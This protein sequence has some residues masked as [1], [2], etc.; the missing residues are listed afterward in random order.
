MKS[1]AYCLP[2][3]P[4]C[5]NHPATHQPHSQNRWMNCCSVAQRSLD[6]PPADWGS[7]S[8]HPQWM[9]A[10]PTPL[11]YTC[12]PPVPQHLLKLPAEHLNC[13]LNCWN[14]LLNTWI[15][16]STVEITRWPPELP[17]QLLKSPADHLNCPLN[18][19]NHPLT[20]W[21]ALSTVEITCWTPESP[22]D[23]GTPTLSTCYTATVE[24]TLWTLEP[25]CHDLGI[26]P[27]HTHFTATVAH[28]WHITCWTPESPSQ[29]LKSPADHLNCPLN[30]WNHHLNTWFTLW[31]GNGYI[32]HLL[33][34]HWWNHPLNTW[35]TLSWLRNGKNIKPISLASL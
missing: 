23:L 25:P 14:C 13:P 17:S 6:N 16:L 33:H 8:G 2:T 27:P 11:S 24:I 7:C 5:L 10:A 18:C 15:A 12:R 29:L 32:T 35:T 31:L 20:T 22:S 26:A 1:L 3:T 4:S 19:W 30:C 9:T 21:I 28:L 34:N